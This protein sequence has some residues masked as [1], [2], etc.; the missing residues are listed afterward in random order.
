MPSRHISPQSF[1]EILSDLGDDPAIPDPQGIRKASSP[2]KPFTSEHNQVHS[3]PKISNFPHPLGNIQELKKW[4]VFLG[5]VLCLF[6]LGA[7][8]WIAFH[9]E[10]QAPNDRL[11]YAHSEITKLQKDIANLRHDLFEIED[12]LYEKID[13]IEV[14]IHLLEKNKVTSANKVKAQTIP[15]EAEI[16]K[17]RYLGSSQMAGSHQAFFQKESGGVIFEKGVLALGEWRLQS[18]DKTLA[19]FTHPSGKSIL[20]QAVKTND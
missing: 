1:N 19:T 16:R 17:W 13:S 12:S 18:I 11:D 15:H 5:G 14:S 6:V 2:Q 7:V 10:T 8:I 4:G 9:A 3:H 20:L